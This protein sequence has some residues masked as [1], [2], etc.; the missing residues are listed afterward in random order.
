M[1]P[2]TEQL[3]DFVQPEPTWPYPPRFRWLKRLSAAGVGLVLLL[4][5][6]RAWWGSEADRRM[7]RTLD[8]LIARGAPV[9]MAD[10]SPSG[11]ADDDNA[12]LYFKLAANKVARNVDS[13]SQSSM[14]FP[15]YP[16][17]GAAWDTMAA[18][19]VAANPEGF[20]L[21]RQARTLD[22]SDW[23]TRFKSPG[24]SVLLP[25]L[26]GARHLAHTISDAALYAHFH[27]DD[28]TA[29]EM[30]A[31]VRHEARAVR[32]EPIV[33]S[34]LVGV[35]IEHLSL[36]KL[37]IMAPAL[38]IGP[39]GMPLP[40][41]PGS[42]DRAAQL[43]PTSPPH[44]PRLASRSQVRA[45]IA[46]LLDEREVV[47]ALKRA[48]GGEQVIQID[49]GEWMG[50]AAPLL[51]PMYQLDAV[52]MLKVDEGVM[53]AAV[54][55]TWPA[56]KAVI[57]TLKSV[58]P[59]AQVNPFGGTVP[60]TKRVPTDHSRLLSSN[61]VGGLSVG[62]AI[63]RNMRLCAERRMTAVSLAAQLY[64]A[65]HGTWPATLDV[66]VPRYLPQVPRDPLA[67]DD[68]P[69]GYLVVAGALPGGADRPVVYSV[70]RDGR[71]DTPDPSVL[72]LVP[73]YGWHNTRDEWRDLSR[74][75]PANVPA[76][77]PK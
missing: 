7:R 29:L 43:L 3:A 40:P 54:Q 13:P 6:T 37:Q 46:D 26:N 19:S 33:V 58:P 35:G 23:G 61:L 48:L 57:A 74:W 63:E 73:L 38:K 17:F 59:A 41:P 66:L 2:M 60:I 65:D 62:Q 47:A 10:L 34:H 45:L 31:D 9:R 49:T 27:G 52:R 14:T 32:A 39:E 16:P 12:A 77:Q 71:D 42:N 75:V 25:H 28:A 22:Q 36:Y 11:V 15:D 53:E 68:R 69:L 1:Q 8:S 70:G 30:I 5:A 18:A 51:R 50:R 64:R 76:A 20:R 72:R 44:P 21:V 24:F 67:M 56:A 4:V 55:P